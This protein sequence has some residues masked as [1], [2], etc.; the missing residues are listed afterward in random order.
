MFFKQLLMIY[1]SNC[2]F[3]GWVSW[4]F[5]YKIYW[6]ILLVHL[7]MPLYAKVRDGCTAGF[8]RLFTKHNKRSPM[9][10]S[11]RVIILSFY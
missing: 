2:K 9:V 7:Q 1:K 6:L 4:Y 8:T 11:T 5:K 10:F 3:K